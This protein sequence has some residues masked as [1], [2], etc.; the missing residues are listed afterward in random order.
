[1]SMSVASERLLDA[2]RAVPLASHGPKVD[3]TYD[4]LTHTLLIPVADTGITN[5]AESV[6]RFFTSPFKS[7]QKRELKILN[8]VSGQLRAG[9]STLVLGNG[10]GGKT[11]L[12]R[13]L[14]ARDGQGTA[15][16]EFGGRVLW[17]GEIPDPL[18]ARKLASFAPQKDIHEPLLTV[19]E[20]LTFAASSCL[21]ALS[22]SASAAEIKL[23]HDLVDMMLDMLE[24][25]EC[26]GVILGDEMKVSL[27]TRK[28]A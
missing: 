7:P 3:V 23:R 2:L 9:T 26:E 4:S 16:G 20:T 1:M 17:N 24:L 11:S 27:K 6:G 12:L 13:R 5:V 10:G 18:H 25:R 28:R 19:R 14:A 15:P 8:G 22:P 21:A